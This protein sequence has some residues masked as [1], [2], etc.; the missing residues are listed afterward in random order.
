MLPAKQPL[1]YNLKALRSVNTKLISLCVG[2]DLRRSLLILGGCERVVNSALRLF[3]FFGSSEHQRKSFPFRSTVLLRRAGKQ[4]SYV[5][6][7]G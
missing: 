1:I 3:C 7:A 4:L 2:C 6:R 5:A